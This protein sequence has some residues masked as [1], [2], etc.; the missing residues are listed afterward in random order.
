PARPPAERS[1]HDVTSALVAANV[2]G[3]QL[4]HQE[5]ASFFIL[6]V[7]AGNETTRN[8]ISHGMRLLTDQ[9]DQ[10]AACAAD[11]E[12]V[13]PTAVEEIVRIASPVI[14]MRRT[15]TKDVTLGGV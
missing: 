6:L 2:D 10:R 3:E 14:F 7:V 9:P 5:L 11:F 4:T 15:A 12:A 8:A 13:A 1:G